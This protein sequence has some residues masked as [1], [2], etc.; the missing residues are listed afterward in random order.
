MVTRFAQQALRT[1]RPDDLRFLAE[2][3]VKSTNSN[4]PSRLLPQAARAVE[5]GLNDE[6]HG[7]FFRKQL[8]TWSID[9]NLLSD[10]AQVVVQVC[11]E[12]LA[13]THPEQALVRL[14]HITRRHSGT[15]GEAARDALL[16]LVDSDRRLY[17]CLLARVTEGLM[18]DT[19]RDLALF[20]E[21]AAPDRL[22]RTPPLIEDAAVRAHLST[23]WSAVLG[24]LSSP[25]CAHPVRTWLAA[26]HENDQYRELLLTV[27]VEGS[28]VDQLSCLYVVARDWAH[29]PGECRQERTGIADRLKGMIDS[30][31]GIDSTEFDLRDRTEGTTP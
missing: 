30:V 25:E 28:G 15:A 6:R 29:S 21:L 27:L 1:N 19:A 16:E 24:G 10:L 11:A 12:V 26:A 17:R 9:I 23:G 20:C 31:L 22:T 7:L 18:K 2:R 4:W 14:H 3:W 5:C 8:Y 13:L